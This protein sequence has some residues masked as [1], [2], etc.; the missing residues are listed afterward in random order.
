[1]TVFQCLSILA[2]EAPAPA[3]NGKAPSFLDPQLLLM[4]GLFAMIFYFVLFRP[5][6]KRRKER[7]AKIEALKKGDTVV[8][9]SGL[10]AKVWRVD[11]NELVLQVDKDKDF[12]ARF[13]KTAVLDVIQDA[14]DKE[15]K[16][17]SED[18]LRQLEAKT[19]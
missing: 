10:I 8:T 4:M 19:R 16:D 11:G 1:M 2:Q 9:S 6:S 12:K 7:M 5:E 14:N 15:K 3:A 13:V 18:A 17:V